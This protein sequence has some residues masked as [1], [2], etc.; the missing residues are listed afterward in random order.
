MLTR[1]LFTCYF[2]VSLMVIGFIALA[3]TGNIFMLSIVILACIG[4]SLSVIRYSRY[5]YEEYGPIFQ[6]I[7][8]RRKKEAN[9]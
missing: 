2:F 5:Y 7:E 9:K 4:F 6:V 3:I 1:W 8:N